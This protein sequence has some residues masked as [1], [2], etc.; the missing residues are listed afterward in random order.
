MATKNL[1][2]TSS[3]EFDI[4]GYL[5]EESEQ[6]DPAVE[7]ALF[8]VDQ[9]TG[10]LYIRVP[11]IDDEED[12]WVAQGQ[13]INT[14]SDDPEDV[15][16]TSPGTEGVL[17]ARGDHVHG[18]GA[19]GSLANAHDAVGIDVTDAA[20][21]FDEDDVEAVLAETHEQLVDHAADSAAHS[22][23]ILVDPG[24]VTY[25]D[26]GDPVGV[27]MQT[28]WGYDG[29]PYFDDEDGAAEGEE[30]ALYWDRVNSTYYLMT[31]DF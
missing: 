30:A 16:T 21:Y 14:Y 24:T 17:A 31:Y 8:Y 12:T 22:P 13:A 9:E 6:E 3:L 5:D 19:Q 25:D 27:T 29:T 1:S 10:I 18:H 28:I 15:G 11:G 26:S 7:S 2:S 23:G 20:G 4:E